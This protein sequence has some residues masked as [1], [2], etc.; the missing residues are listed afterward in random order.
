MAPMARRERAWQRLAR[1]L[2]AA[3][4]ARMT[5]VEAMTRL[6]ELAQAILA[7][8]TQGRVVIDVTR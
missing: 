2:D 3:A 6:P 7:G 4:L 1:D 5:R 8:Q